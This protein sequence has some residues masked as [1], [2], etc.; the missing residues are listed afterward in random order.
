MTSDDYKAFFRRLAS[1]V[2]VVT[3][4]IEARLH[5]FTATSVT[6]VSAVPPILLFCVCQQNESHQHLGIGRRVGISILSREQKDLSER[7]AA[8]AGQD[9]YRHIETIRMPRGAPT[10]RDALAQME[11]SVVDVRPV[12]DHAIVLVEFEAVITSNANVPIL[13]YNRGYHHPTSL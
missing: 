1:G 9:G 11:G 13:Y 4:T 2:C 3:F 5:G 12:G 7:F 10:L 8:K 6:S